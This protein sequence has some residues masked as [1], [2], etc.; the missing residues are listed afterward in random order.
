MA[1][2]PFQVMTPIYAACASF[3][4]WTRHTAI[5]NHTRGGPKLYAQMAA[6]AD[7]GGDSDSETSQGSGESL[8]DERVVTTKRALQDLAVV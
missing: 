1:P 7:A 6:A 3:G 4:S 8:G 5:Y 2:R